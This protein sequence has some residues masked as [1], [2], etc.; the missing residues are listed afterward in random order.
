MSISTTRGDDGTT[1]FGKGRVSKGSL[2]AEAL[3]AL[4]EFGAALGFARSLCPVPW[5]RDRVE[6]LQRSLFTVAA[7]LGAPPDQRDPAARESLRALLDEITTEVHRL[8]AREGMLRDWALPGG[9]AG[10]AAMDLARTAC[11]RSERIL[12][13]LAEASG[14]PVVVRR[15]LLNRMSDLIWLYGRVIETE[16]GISGA[17]R[18]EDARRAGS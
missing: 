8:E 15:A 12:V 6:R 5:I 10:A 4:D 16:S 2:E 7:E 17:L 18:R 11:R 13:R 9:H 3:G 14:V 1:Q